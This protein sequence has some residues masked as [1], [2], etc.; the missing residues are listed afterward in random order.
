MKVLFILKH[1]ENPYDGEDRYGHGGGHLSSGLANSARFVREMLQDNGVQ[2]ELEQAIDNNCID[3]LVTKHKPTHVII[4]A[5]WVV[6]EKFEVLTKL[7]PKVKWIIRNH[8]EL[9]FLASEGIAIDWTCRYVDF[10]NVFVSGNSPRVLAEMRTIIRDS[11]PEWSEWLA[12]AKVW[13]LPNFYKATWRPRLLPLPASHVVNVG[14]FG[15]IR[16]L[17]NHLLQAVAAIQ[18]ADSIGKKLRF[19]I[20]A[21]RIEG[22]ATSATLNNLRALFRHVKHHELVEHSWMDH[23]EF[24]KLLK[25]EI[26][27]GLCVSHSETFCIVAAD[28]VSSGV[29]LVVSDEVYWASCLSKAEPNSSRD[30]VRKM[31]TAWRYRKTN[32]LETLNMW[33]LRRFCA[34]T[35]VQWLKYFGNHIEK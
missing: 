27:I 33:G 5:Y 15:A 6:P 30:I 10:E 12:N 25:D 31:R 29:P 7:H 8:S 35:K 9:P 14:C 34:K 26:E 13:Y 3:R 17:K 21:T 23:Q 20:N 32:V 24:I 1:R 22:G 19:H 2:A 16:P 4:E 28:M 11:H 18:F